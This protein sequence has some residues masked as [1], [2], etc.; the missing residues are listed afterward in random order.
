M[1]EI[2]SAPT[3]KRKLR[4]IR[5]LLIAFGWVV[6]FF[7]TLWA[8][9]ALYFDL[10]LPALRAPA[11][12]IFAAVMLLMVVFIKP[13]WRAAVVV[14]SG[15]IAVLCWWFALKPS[16]TRAWQPDVAQTPWAEIRGDEVM[17]HNVRNCDYA[18]ETNFTP[19]WETRTVRLS[20]L[21]G[22]DLALTY[23]GSPWMAHPIVSFQFADA[24]PVAFSI[25]TR[26][27]VGESYSAVRGF[28][29]QFELIYIVADERDVVRLRT[30]YR[31]G[32][33]VY[34]YRTKATPEEARAR[35]LEY[36]SRI[37]QLHQQP[38]WYNALTANCTTSIRTQRAAGRRSTFDWRMILN[39]KS[40]EMVYERGALRGDLPF[41]ELK[42]LALIN[43]RARA[44]DKSSEF[45]QA[46]RDGMPW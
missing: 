45:S 3:T 5:W 28:F 39:G 46:I 18:T 22:I 1:S 13:R 14:A 12:A 38:V 25:E 31:Q 29:R 24:R 6:L 4:F 41:A 27:E 20:Q 37:N 42:R 43:A 9:A 7:L 15:F 10:P 23:W 32:E 21:T 36:V 8:A 30:N 34:L 44:A 26:K 35:F 40:D 11:A 33:D 16:G 2:V 19:H 17:L